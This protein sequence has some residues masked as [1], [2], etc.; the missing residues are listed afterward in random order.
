M[1]AHSALLRFVAKAALNHVGFG[2]GGDF[3]VEVLP[4]L[5]K[6]AWGWWNKGKTAQQLRDDLQAVAALSPAEA[7]QQAAAAVALEAPDADLAMRLQ[8]TTYLEQVPGAIRRSQTRPNDPSGRTV[9]SRLALTR[10]ED[11]IVLLPQRVP[12]FKAGDRPPGVGDWELVELLGVGGFGEV[13][14]AKNPHLP[15]PVAFKFCLDRQAAVGLRNEAALLG[16]V[17]SQA[18]QPSIVRLLDTNLSA[19]PPF[20][21]YEYVSGGDLTRLVNLQLQKHQGKIPPDQVR[22]IIRHLA[23]ALSHPHQQTPPIVHR[24]MKPANVLVQPKPDGTVALRITDFGI[25]GVAATQ[26]IEQAQKATTG[27]GAT[28][29]QGAHTPLYA[30]PQQKEGKQPDPRDDV[31]ALGVMWYQMLVGDLNKGAPHGNGWKWPLIERG[32]TSEEL[33]LLQACFEDEPDHRP[34]DAKV[35]ADRIERFAKQAP[36]VTISSSPNPAVYGQP[37]TLTAAVKPPSPQGEVP[38][39]TV[40]FEAGPTNLGSVPLDGG[41]A[42]LTAPALSAGSHAITARYGGD[43]RFTAGNP[44]SANL[45]VAPAPLTV[46][47][48]DAA[49]PA[50]QPNP[51]FAASF[52]GF[53]NGEGESS[54]AGALSFTTPAADDAPAGTFPVTPGGLTSDN[55]AITFVS[56]TLTVTEVIRPSVDPLAEGAAR[57]EQGEYAQAIKLFTDALRGNPNLAAAY[58]LRSR[59]YLRRGKP[60]KA[61]ADLDQLNKLEPKTPANL[62]ERGRL[63]AEAGNLD[64]AIGDFDQAVFCGGRSVEVLVARGRAHAAKGVWELALSDFAAALQLAPEDAAVYYHRG[65]ARLSQSAFDQASADFSEAARLRPDDARYPNALGRVCL[66]QGKPDDALAKFNE[67]SHVDPHCVETYLNR[68]RVWMERGQTEEAIDDLTRAVNFDPRNAGAYA[69]RG[70]AR[71]RLG[72]LGHALSD[73]NRAVKLRPGDP[74]YHVGRGELL[75]ERGEFEEAV[76]DFKA[77]IKLDKHSPAAYLGRGRARLACGHP[78]NAINDFTQALQIV[79]GNTGALLGR[80]QAHLLKRRYDEAI[81]DAGEVI[82]LAPATAPAFRVRAIAYRSKK[83]YAPAVA[84]LTEAIRLEPAGGCFVD[85][86]LAHYQAGDND[87]AVADFTAAIKADAKNP[88]YY[89]HRARAHEKKGDKEKAREDRAK[90]T[91]LNPAP[92]SGQGVP[93]PDQ[94]RPEGKGGA[95]GGGPRLRLPQARVLKALMPAHPGDPQSEWPLCARADLAT[96]AGYTPISGTVTR[97]LNGICAHSD[98]GRPHSG[99]I[100]LHLV[101]VINVDGATEVNYRITPAGIRAY[102]QYAAAKGNKLPAVKDAATCT[103]DRYKHQPERDG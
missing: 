95:G 36:A 37:V 60:G 7:C 75:H 93:A 96:R 67:A 57:L 11:L 45:S 30:S 41:S 54:L 49:K 40:T 21:K 52:S 28:V 69:M 25:G 20:L 5:V 86:G 42:S 29:L 98:S 35:L 79:P 48:H 44:A 84:D 53:V 46:T 76:N 71:S 14:K 19:D 83:E 62:L 64:R 55:Y 91:A 61:L 100:D 90:A 33:D 72:K 3:A 73:Y 32:M 27:H 99:L 24:D 38:S 17:C 43:A 70:L 74:S 31:H 50:G 97:A 63:H 88:E 103:N 4:E 82:R 92:Q 23:R 81:T 8:L 89:Q 10:P 34:A 101:E 80:A 26:A 58:R 51:A 85:R 39:G 1:A 77:A 9:S 56:G 47:A 65:E 15:E 18:Q 59:A 66:R 6:T 13:W 12:K 102:Q 22:K 87:A 68:A 2:V 94:H 16:R 78:G